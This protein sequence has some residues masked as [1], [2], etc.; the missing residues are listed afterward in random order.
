MFKFRG[1]AFDLYNIKTVVFLR[2]LKRY[3]IKLINQ[4]KSRN[5]DKM[6]VE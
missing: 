3:R 5:F 1:V 2:K 6:L 4:G